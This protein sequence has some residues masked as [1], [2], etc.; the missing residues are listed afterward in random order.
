MTIDLNTVLESK[1][2]LQSQT[3]ETDIGSLQLKDALPLFGGDGA[4]D[5]PWESAVG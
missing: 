3:K 4:A 2:E 5:I 1:L